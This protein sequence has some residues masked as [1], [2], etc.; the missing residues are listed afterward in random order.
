MWDGL[1]TRG[2][3][4]SHASA[5]EPTFCG[6]GG[7]QALVESD[8]ADAFLLNSSPHLGS[9]PLCPAVLVFDLLVALAATARVRFPLFPES[10]IR[11]RLESESDVYAVY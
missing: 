2:S 7:W 8:G 4:L 11:S 1:E 3:H 6:Q 10:F 9:V 5:A